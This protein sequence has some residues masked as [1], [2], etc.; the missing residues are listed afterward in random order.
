MTTNSFKLAFA[1]SSEV[2]DVRTFRAHESLSELFELDVVAVSQNEAVDLDAIVGKGAA[3]WVNPVLSDLNRGSLAMP[4]AWA[5]IVADMSVSALTLAQATY[6]IKIAPMLWRS[7]LRKNLRIYQ[8]KTT[9]VIVKELLA[10]W[11][12]TPVMELQEQY[13]A[14]EYCVQYDESDFAFM[15]RLLEEAGI[16]YA[17]T[18]DAT[19]RRGD[20][21]TRLVLKDKPTDTKNK[22]KQPLAYTDQSDAMTADLNYCSDV[23]LRQRVRAGRFAVR[24]WDFRAPTL[25]RLGKAKAGTLEDAYEQYSYDP[26]VFWWDS[27]KTEK[28]VADRDHGPNVVTATMDPT[29]KREMDAARRAR[30]LVDMSTNVLDLLPGTVFGINQ[31]SP[32]PHHPRADLAPEVPLLVVSSTIEGA[33]DGA[34]T[35]KA[36][37]V[38]AEHT[39]R[40][41][42]VTDRPRVHGVQSALVVGPPGEEIF[43]DEFGRVRVQFHWDRDGNYD[44][45]SSCWLR[46]SNPW[47]GGSF[48]MINIPRV[49]HEVLVEFFEGNPDMPVIIGRVHNGVTGVPYA[50]PANKTKSGW[51]SNSYPHGTGFNEISFEDSAGSEE[52]HVQAE[53]NLSYIVKHDESSNIGDARTVTIGNADTLAVG[54]TRTMTIGTTDTLAVGMARSATIGMTDTT[55]VG[56]SHKVSV[57]PTVGTSMEAQ[58]KKIIITTGDASITLVGPDIFLNAKG[59]IHLHA[60]KELHLSSEKGTIEIQG[61]PMVKINEGKSGP[62]PHVDTVSPAT[63]PTPP[64]SPAPGAPGTPPFLPEGTKGPIDPPVP[65]PDVKLD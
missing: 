37:C 27:D 31:M 12:I 4:R 49:G 13:P 53:K 44:D 3:L 38:F 64:G 45:K 46:V 54:K 35:G 9:P 42:R 59:D 18:H 8:H 19:K 2:L 51:K 33:T 39:Y 23:T 43:T 29:A 62:P 7:T 16:T 24:D 57:G 56:M 55:M 14:H 32:A 41:E 10:E 36:S 22:R 28:P 5:G 15:S 25:P 61:G 60:G 26:G 6:R 58:S 47:S 40:P 48:G 65:V 34:V 63:P 52:I 17:F 11:N 1:Q 21:I 20:E 50:L 30:L